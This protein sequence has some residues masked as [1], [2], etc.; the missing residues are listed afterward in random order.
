MLEKRTIKVFILLLLCSN[1]MFAQLKEV[2]IYEKAYSENCQLFNKHLRF[3][4][5][6]K[7][8]LSILNQYVNKN[9]EVELVLNFTGC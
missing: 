9:K 6:T 4:A 8:N 3:D 7:S 1:A 2:R 5:C